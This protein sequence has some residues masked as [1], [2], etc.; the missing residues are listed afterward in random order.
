VET[1]SEG[2]RQRLQAMAPTVRIFFNLD[3]VQDILTLNRPSLTDKA[4]K[5]RQGN[6]LTG[7]GL[8]GDQLDR[9]RKNQDG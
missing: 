5:I 7:K 9:C 6:G 2:S 8:G 3:L 4:Q 1:H